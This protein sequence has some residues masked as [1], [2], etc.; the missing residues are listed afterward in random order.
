[1][2]SPLR[3]CCDFPI[4][5]AASAAEINWPLRRIAERIQKEF[6]Y[7]FPCSGERSLLKLVADAVDETADAYRAV[8]HSLQNQDPQ[9]IQQCLSLKTRSSYGGVLATSL[10]SQDLGFQEDRIQ[11]VRG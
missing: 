4:D 9:G 1:M 10:E 3:K 6:G 2:Q 5:M 8:L 11:Q 7:S